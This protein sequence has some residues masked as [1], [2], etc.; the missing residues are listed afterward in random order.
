MQ[1]FLL[2]RSTHMLDSAPLSLSPTPWE[3]HWCP[4]WVGVLPTLH[5][6]LP[7]IWGQGNPHWTKLHCTALHCTAL[8]CTALQQI[9]LHCTETQ[10]ESDC[11]YDS[12]NNTDYYQRPLAQC[13]ITNTVYSIFDTEEIHS[14]LIKMPINIINDNSLT[15][16]ATFQ[17]YRLSDFD[18]ETKQ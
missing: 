11:C 2:N 7:L 13:G 15:F 5:H 4:W 16:Y 10:C 3:C 1:G 17:T 8:H 18:I 12:D 6:T 9:S 14:C